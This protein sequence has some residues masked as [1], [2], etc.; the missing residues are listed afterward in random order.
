MEVKRE[1]EIKKRNFYDNSKKL[2]LSVPA[3]LGAA[4]TTPSNPAPD[5][6]ALFLH[7]SGT[8]SRPKLVPLT[9]RNL[10]VSISNIAGTYPL[11]FALISCSFLIF[12]FIFFLFCFCFNFL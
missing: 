11:F 8:T 10:S 3:P 2:T 7:T 1:E 6:V 4:T 5:D 9:H 12:L